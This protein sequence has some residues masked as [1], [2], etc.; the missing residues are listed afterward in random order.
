METK[1]FERLREA[2]KALFYWDYDVFY[3]RLPRENTPPYTHE[4][5]EFIL[6]NLKI[7]PNELPEAVFD[8]LGKPKMYVSS[9]LR[10]R[11]HKHVIYRNGY[12]P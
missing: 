4:A 7:F 11:M 12:V 10:L 2:G 1:F 3:T 5:G 6:R 9:L 8:T